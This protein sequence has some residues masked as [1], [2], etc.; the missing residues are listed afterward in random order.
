MEKCLSAILWILQDREKYY[1]RVRWDQAVRA[2]EMK[3]GSAVGI[4]EMS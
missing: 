3:F 4:V 2:Q 1:F